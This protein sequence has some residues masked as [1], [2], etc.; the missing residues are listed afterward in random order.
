MATQAARRTACG[1]D[2]LSMTKYLIFKKV[3]GE[4]PA[5]GVWSPVGTFEGHDAKSAI[6]AAAAQLSNDGGEIADGTVFAATPEGSWRTQ[7]VS[8]KV[9]PK[10]RFA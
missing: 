3:A 2:T 8:V 6:S 10:V 1:K 4:L 9:E 7:A 5:D